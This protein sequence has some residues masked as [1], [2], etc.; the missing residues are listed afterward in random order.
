MVG[1]EA[2]VEREGDLL[3]LEQVVLRKNQLLLKPGA[4]GG[5]GR[6]EGVGSA[7]RPEGV[8]SGEGAVED[9]EL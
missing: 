5:G 8:E 6:G 3:R 7:G 2:A 4:A 1:G 9:C